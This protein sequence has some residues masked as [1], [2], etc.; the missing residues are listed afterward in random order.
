MPN[1]LHASA[2]DFS[3]QLAYFIL[4]LFLLKLIAV[5]FSDTSFGKALAFIVG[6]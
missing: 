5:R 2:L 1:H 4:A 6:L 3:V